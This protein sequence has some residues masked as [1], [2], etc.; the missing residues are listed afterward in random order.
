[1]R[2]GN[3]IMAQAIDEITSGIPAIRNIGYQRLLG[4]GSTILALPKGLTEFYK[5]K[6][7]VSDEELSELRKFVP[8]WS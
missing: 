1:M 4:F 2:T 3:N 8:E 7:N 5:A 6:N